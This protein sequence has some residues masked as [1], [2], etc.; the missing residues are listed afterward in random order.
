MEGWAHLPGMKPLASLIL[1]MA[2]CLGGAARGA[3]DEVLIAVA[4]NFARPAEALAERFESKT[5]HTV[6]L[7][8]GSTG[9]LYAQIRHGAPFDVFLAADQARPAALV[10]DGFAEAD[11]LRTYAIGRLV[12]VSSRQG[13]DDPLA[14]LEARDVTR[15]AL[16]NADLAPYGRAA[17]Q[18]LTR[19]D[20]DLPP[21]QMIRGQNIA[22]TLVTFSTGN[23]DLA[24][25]ARSQLDLVRPAAAHPIPSGW[26]DPI[27]QDA[28]L[29]TRGSGN[30]AAEAWMDF[31]T[32][33]A[34]AQVLHNHGYGDGE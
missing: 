8:T 18:V 1:A 23:A 33:P 22:Q 3:C 9:A 31:L 5:G 25:I 15:L 27:R 10:D 30:P 6:R 20:T 14:R 11:S 2:L 26:H 4:A 24:F 12:L 32:S 21:H 13:S 29:L 34:A 16:A 28:V 7:A 19:L 17:E